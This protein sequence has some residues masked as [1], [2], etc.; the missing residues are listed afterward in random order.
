MSKTYSLAGVTLEMLNGQYIVTSIN[1]G[2]PLEIKTENPIIAVNHFTGQI[3]HILTQRIRV[4]LKNQN[5]NQYTG[6]NQ[7]ELTC[8][9]CKLSGEYLNCNCPLECKEESD[10][11]CD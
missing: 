2:K 8:H 3:N 5:K 4:F 11:Q 10:E 1:Y 6:C 7:L 9:E